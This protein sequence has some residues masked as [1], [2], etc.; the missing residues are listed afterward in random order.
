LTLTSVDVLHSFWVP[1]LAGKLDLVPGR[2]NRLRLVANRPG[3]YRGQCAEY[4]GGPHAQMAFL[5][6]AQAPGNFDAWRRAQ[7]APAPAAAS[8]TAERGR[9]VFLAHCASCHTVRGTPA[10][11]TLGPDLTHVGSRFTLAAGILPNNPGTIAAWVA[12]SQRIKPGNLM[13][14]FREFG[15]AELSALASYVEHLK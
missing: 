14:A 1:A 7:R 11:G 4:C 15:G 2:A 6:V 12:E 5:V 3:I 9:S 13:P 10:A 8:A